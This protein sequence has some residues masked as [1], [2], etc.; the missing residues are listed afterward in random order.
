[1][2][3]RAQHHRALRLPMR[4]PWRVLLLL[5]LLAG[6][7]AMH[8]LGPGN[9]VTAASAHHPHARTMTAAHMPATTDESV[10]H[11]G[12]TGG[13]H[14]QH[15]DPTCASGAVGAG[16][17]LPALLPDPAGG[18]V[19]GDLDGRSVAAAP[20]GGRAPPSLAELQILRT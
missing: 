18:A 3:A 19:S 7:F 17:A 1:M 9:T 12:T 20:E 16:P 6:L 10:C 8:G 5:G 14:A 15:A 2:T 11:G 4:G 13:G